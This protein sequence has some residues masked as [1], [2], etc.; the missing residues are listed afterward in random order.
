[1]VGAEGGIMRFSAL[2]TGLCVLLLIG[3]GTR[4]ARAVAVDVELALAVD[5]SGSTDATE[6]AQMING[7]A[8]AFRSP[9]VQSAIAAGPNQQIAVSMYFWTAVESNGLQ[10]VK[11]PFTAVSQASADAFADRIEDLLDPISELETPQGTLEFNPPLREP[12]FLD[13][14]ALQ[15]FGGTGVGTGFTAVAQA[16]TFGQNLLLAENGFEALRK[17]LD[18]SGDGQE[19]VDHNPTGCEDAEFCAPLGQIYDPLSSVI[20]RPEIYSAAVAAARDAALAAG[21]TTINGLP[22]ENDISD[23]EE[24]FYVPFVIGGEGAFARTA[25]G[26]DTF[27][28]AI[29]DKLEG[30]I[31]PEPS[32][33]ALV[34]LGLLSV[35]WARARTA[36][37]PSARG[38]A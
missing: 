33:G 8:S 25:T 10:A 3:A 20:I 37:G 31:A 6:F 12:Y 32:L 28:A 17:V 7:Y 26:F 29:E 27:S 5:V 35:S 4:S 18:V 22:I 1:M 38:S 34:L 9:S 30:E 14:D 36:R 11:I 23:L 16:I 24:S 2:G 21:V 13:L 19:N 15:V